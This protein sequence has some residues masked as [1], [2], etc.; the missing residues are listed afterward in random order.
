MTT[1][2]LFSHPLIHT[3]HFLSHTVQRIYLA[4]L[5]PLNCP[6]H[7]STQVDCIWNVMAHTQEP[8][9]VFRR[10]GRVHLN[11]RVVSSNAGSWGVRISGSNAGYTTFWGS[12]NSTGYPLHLPVSSSV[13]HHLPSHF[14]WTLPTTTKH[15]PIFLKS[16]LLGS[17]LQSVMSHTSAHL[18]AGTTVSHVSCYEK[19]KL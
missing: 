15:W 17:S 6:I 5:T 11:Q 7:T 12:V 16:I 4:Q 13:C 19:L 1:S 2:R 3:S 18:Y 9:F 14:N 8:D 10:N